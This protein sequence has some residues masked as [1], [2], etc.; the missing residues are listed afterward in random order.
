MILD[1]FLTIM[2]RH[3]EM[4]ILT[5]EL[6]EIL[7]YKEEYKEEE[8]EVYLIIIQSFYLYYETKPRSDEPFLL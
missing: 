4:G 1:S 8:E 7:Y 5:K 2:F 6:F 3:I